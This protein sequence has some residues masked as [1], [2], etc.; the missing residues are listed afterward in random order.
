MTTEEKLELLL[1]FLALADVLG[2]PT[3]EGQ[4]EGLEYE[5]LKTRGL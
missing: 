2:T 1:G 4:L 5:G 3:S